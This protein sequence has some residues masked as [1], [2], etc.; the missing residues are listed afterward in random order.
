[1]IGVGRRPDKS[2][3]SAPLA[4]ARSRLS[5]ASTVQAAFPHNPSCRSTYLDAPWD[6]TRLALL[7]SETRRLS[8]VSCS[9][10]LMGEPC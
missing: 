10:A 5:V 8:R 1:M 7:P 9:V 6:L 2:Y 4:D 3:C